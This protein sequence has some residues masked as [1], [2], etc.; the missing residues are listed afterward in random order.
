MKKSVNILFG[1]LLLL[2]LC[3]PE[4]AVA[5]YHHAGEADAPKFLNVYPDKAGTKLDNCALCHR[6]G[7]TT[8]TKP[9]TL[10]SCQWCHYK[11]GYDASGVITETL[12]DYGKDYL[13][14]GRS[15]AALREIES[16]DSDGDLYS[17]IVEIQAIRYPGDVKDDPSKV[18]ASH[19]IYTKAQ[20]EAMPQH[21][22]F[23]LMNTT[24]SGDYYTEYS[25]VTMEYLLN[26]TKISPSATKV[27]V[28]SP[29]G[30]SQGHP[31]QDSLGNTGSSYA[32]FVIGAYP[33]AYYYYNEEEADKA[34]NTLYGW[35][36]YS[37][38][39]TLGRNHGDTIA[40]TDGLRLLLALRAEGTDLVPGV[41][42]LDNKLTPRSEG[43]FRVVAPQKIVGPPD[44]P[45]TNPTQGAIW[46]YDS[47]ADHNAG[48]STKCTTIIKVEPLPEGT[49][50]ID[51][52]EAG[53]FY[54][55]QSKIVVYGAIEG[56]QLT[57]PANGATGVS[58]SPTTFNWNQSPGI[59]TKDI[60]SYRLEY[61]DVDPALGKWKT[62]SLSTG[63]T[64]TANAVGAKGLGFA[65]FGACGMIGLVRSK[66]S[67][68][69]LA[70]ILIV[71]LSGA[72]LV[73]CGGDD[74]TTSSMAT[75]CEAVTLEANTTYWWRVADTDKNGGST[76]SETFSFTTG[77]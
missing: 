33:A 25:G 65:L 26:K 53:W 57:S 62:A 72:T 52:L 51:V 31:L 71:A 4:L 76:V 73:S 29:D 45:S 12:N 46:Q 63:G 64:V 43:P 32:P 61:T 70:V 54:V 34:I 59:D 49:T 8:D 44:Q 77:K 16:V 42:G 69:Y 50:D 20:L 35:V 48:F 22:Q 40:V 68:R 67:R 7:T 21:T 10:G 5:A 39:G 74:S 27:T 37:S 18:I 55:D 17:N 56:P 75:G 23:M 3:L 9:K 28:Y 1:G 15:E 14:K 24:K 47:N 38:P 2:A 41:L 30:F 11:Y 19:R 36:D 6:G 58:H 13:A 66:G 60:V